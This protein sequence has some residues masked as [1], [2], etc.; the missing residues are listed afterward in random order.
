LLPEVR[1]TSSAGRFLPMLRR[2][3][4][5]EERARE[6]VAEI[7]RDGS[8]YCPETNRIYAQRFSLSGAAAAASRFVLAACSGSLGPR[9][10]LERASGEDRFYAR[11]LSEALADFGARILHSGLQPV[12]EEELFSRCSSGGLSRSDLGRM[13][14][15]VSLHRHFECNPHLYRE[16]PRLIYEGRAYSGAKLRFVSALLGQLLGARFYHAYL[17]GTV[18]RRELRSLYGCGLGKPGQSKLLYFQLAR[19]DGVLSRPT[20]SSPGSRSSFYRSNSNTDPALRA[21]EKR[22]A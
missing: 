3:I 13:V 20:L 14:E 18:R 12:Q 16:T 5:D 10:E 19:R 8:A 6:L 2:R 4:G 1:L 22:A 9:P 7:E 15:F 11:C 17:K 21:E